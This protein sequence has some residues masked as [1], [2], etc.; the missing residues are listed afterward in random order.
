MMVTATSSWADQCLDNIKAKGVLLSG[1][2]LMGTKPFI[3]K[4][5]DGTYQGFEWDI[6]QEI[7]KRMGVAKVDYEITEWSTL[8]PGLKADRWDIILSAMSAT[9]ERIKNAGVEFSS[10]YFLLI[11][12]V[13]VKKDSAIQSMDDLKGKILGTTMG[14][15]DSLNAHRLVT[16]G[17]AGSVLDYNSF[18]E[19]FVALQNGQVD[20]VILDQ[21]TFAGQQEAL[22]NMRTVGEPIY[23]QPKPEWAEAEG[24]AHYILGS[25]AVAVKRECPDLL[26]AIN[27]ALASMEADGTRKAILEKYGMWADYQSK[28]TK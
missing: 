4:N 3:W 12:H 13:I 5:E 25:S 14:T 9:Q 22:G 16:E 6:F 1:N 28:M 20:A 18:G 24:K 19:P 11:D 23:Y 2:G 7:G 15:N 17:K 10:P 27:T 8:I 26:A 21:G